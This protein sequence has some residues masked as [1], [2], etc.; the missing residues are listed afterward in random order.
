[1]S[2]ML[3]LL[4]AGLLVLPVSAVGQVAGTAGAATSAAASKGG[5]TADPYAAESLVVERMDTVYRYAQDGTGSKQI[6]AVTRIQSDAS[7]R[8]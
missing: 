4:V 5:T 3:G 8:H 6:A 7:A 1:M 2:S